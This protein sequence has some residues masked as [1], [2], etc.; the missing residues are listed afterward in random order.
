[1][2]FSPFV[3]IKYKNQNNDSREIFRGS[4]LR[5]DCRGFLEKSRALQSSAFRCYRKVTKETFIRGE[6]R[7]SEQTSTGIGFD[8]EAKRGTGGREIVTQKREEGKKVKGITFKHDTR[9]K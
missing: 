1:M 2:V 7:E 9:W 4:G 6:V 8:T 5:E 3:Q